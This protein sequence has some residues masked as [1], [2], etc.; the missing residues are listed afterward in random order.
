MDIEKLLKKSQGLLSKVRRENPKD[1]ATLLSTQSETTSDQSD[2]YDWASLCPTKEERR[3]K[4]ARDRALMYPHLVEV[5][6]PSTFTPPSVYGWD[7]WWE[8]YGVQ[9]G[10]VRGNGKVEPVGSFISSYPEGMATKLESY[11]WDSQRAQD[12]MRGDRSVTKALY[13]L[14]NHD[15]NQ[16]RWKFLHSAVQHALNKNYFATPESLYLEW[17]V[18]TV[19][20]FDYLETFAEQWDREL[21]YTLEPPQLPDI[22][23]L[24]LTD[25]QYMEYYSRSLEFLE[26]EAKR[27]EFSDEPG[28]YVL[29]GFTYEAEPLRIMIRNS[30]KLN[31]HHI[32]YWCMVDYCLNSDQCWPLLVEVVPPMQ[33]SAM[34]VIEECELTGDRLPVTEREPRKPSLEELIMRSTV[35][36]LNAVKRQQVKLA[37]ALENLNVGRQQATGEPAGE[38]EGTG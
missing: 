19:N 22:H 12:A 21:A 28:N 36:K 31:M 16:S 25:K 35:A 37:P 10:F 20:K 32:L 24:C 1:T 8:H 13:D 29:R 4:K 26:D 17:Q 14:S 34:S 5:P 3:A 2:A 33:L 38:A 15:W 6:R 30:W 27:R 23:A 7:Y 18:A 9:L 11:L